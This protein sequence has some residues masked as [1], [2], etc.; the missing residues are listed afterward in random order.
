MWCL[1]EE[2]VN[3]VKTPWNSLNILAEAQKG[4]FYSGV[5]IFNNLTKNVKNLSSD[6]NKFNMA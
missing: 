1:K 4:V 6:A 5:T 3:Q 2:V